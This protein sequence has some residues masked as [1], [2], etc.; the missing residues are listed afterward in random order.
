M[1]SFNNVIFSDFQQTYCVS[2]WSTDSISQDPTMMLGW[3]T[4]E[5]QVEQVSIVTTGAL[6]SEKENRKNW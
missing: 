1:L 4:C 6:N 3:V 5:K 2:R